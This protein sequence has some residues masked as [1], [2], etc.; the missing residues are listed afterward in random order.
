[1]N[2]QLFS[3]AGLVVLAIVALVVTIVINM[4]FRG[5]RVDLSEDSLYTLSEG[6]EHLVRNL[7]EQVTLKFYFSKG[8]TEGIPQIRNYARRIQEVLQEYVQVSDGRVKLEVID[9]EPFSEHED[10]ASGYALQAVPLSAGGQS[11]YMGL[12]ALGAE[13]QPVADGQDA[14]QDAQPAKRKTEVISFISPDKERFL[15]YD[16]SN[17][18]YTASLTT[19]PKLGVISSIALTGG[20]YDMMT[21]QPNQPWYSMTQLDKL[22][23]VQHLNQ[24]VTA[25][26]G[27]ISLLVLVLPELTPAARYAVDQYVLKGGHTLVFL[28]PYAEAAGGG[29][30]GMM[31]GGGGSQSAYL[32]SLLGVWGVEMVK[33]RFVAD[34]QHALAVG[35]G[36][37][38]PVRHLGLVGYGQTNFNG[39]DVVTGNLKSV[40]FSSAGALRVKEGAKVVF[41]P[42]IESSERSA[43]LDSAQ[44]AMLYDPKVL[45]KGFQP[46]GERYTL[47]A[48][49]SGTLKTAF[50]EGKPAPDKAGPDA[51]DNPGELNETSAV[52]EQ[53]E[54]LSTAQV[55]DSQPLKESVK[56]ANLIVVSDTDVLS[57]RLWV[58][59]AQFFG[60]QMMTPFANNGDMVVNMIDNLAGNADLISIRSRGQ[61]SRP[62]T[63]VD[64]LERNAQA[65]FLK[66]EEEL[67]KQLQDTEKRLMELQMQKS[68]KEAM[69]VSDEQ[70][71]ELKKFK[72]EK[73]KIRKQLRDVQHQLN[74]DIEQLGSTLKLVNI[75]LVPVILT[76]IALFWR[77]R[78]RKV[79]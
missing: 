78:R 4:V 53:E 67:S 64:E 6:T 50:P 40:N 23:D 45:F 30:Q 17:L 60:Q 62:F 27:D 46:T 43:L 18:I 29:S 55:D 24:S 1:M 15:E 33:D 68:G 44:L 57:N 10:E 31:G 63:R 28:D 51:S 12:V 49:I 37:G 32:E 75:F 16:I 5:A 72:Q 76:I 9:P 22:Y 65:R 59:V 11:V 39:K 34:E 71:Q 66:T 77:M 8:Q 41:E 42:L 61:F 48:R 25:I 14:A 69:V 20:G 56:P 36:M 79:A 21:R 58:Q 3:K 73:L 52:E 35:G 47:A 38:R 7:P 13:Q 74:R 70:V 2:N 26:P 19:K 54:E